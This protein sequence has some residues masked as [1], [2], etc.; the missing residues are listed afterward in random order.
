MRT[1]LFWL[2][3]IAL[4]AY[5]RILTFRHGLLLQRMPSETTS[6]EA[7]ATAF[8]RQ[9]IAQEY[10]SQEATRRELL[11]QAEQAGPL[12]EWPKTLILIPFRDRWDLTQQC[13]ESL[14]L[15]KGF[16]TQLASGNLKVI[17]IDNLSRE[18]STIQGMAH[19]IKQPGIEIFSFREQ[20][21]FSR[22]NNLA[23][24][25]QTDFKPDVLFFLNNDV[26]FQKPD[27]L[28]NLVGFRSPNAGAWGCTLRYPNGRIQHLF[29]APGV[30]IVGAHLLRGITLVDTDPWLRSPWPVPAVT[31]AALLVHGKHFES[32]G[33]FDESLATA[34]QD[35]DLC[36]KLKKNGLQQ[37]SLG[38][39]QLV[40]HETAT[41]KPLHL[42][43]EVDRMYEKWGDQL[44]WSQDL[45]DCISRWSELALARWKEREYPHSL[46]LKYCKKKTS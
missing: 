44:R 19:W 12:R 23:V 3:K 27:D 34:Y 35:L 18:A 41:R 7:S 21:N 22:M 39:V 1:L 11:T 38:Y 4:K 14:A 45:P 2:I 26:S 40:H 16:G 9:A 10:P 36:L 17:L 46:Y 20:F 43:T 29:L 24:E 42:P 25:S 32:V 33:G 8:L 6:S 15:Q 37:W 28:E 30:K 5:E 13:L 31:G